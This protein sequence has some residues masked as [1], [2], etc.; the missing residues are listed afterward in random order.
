[1]SHLDKFSELTDKL[2]FRDGVE[3]SWVSIPPS[4]TETT[5]VDAPL[6]RSVQ[7]SPAE[8]IALGLPA[9]GGKLVE[10]DLLLLDFPPEID[11]HS[12]IWF[13]LVTKESSSVPPEDFY[14][15]VRESMIPHLT[16]E[17]IMSGGLRVDGKQQRDP[18]RS[19]HNIFLTK[20]L[21]G[22][23]MGKR[24]LFLLG[25]GG[26]GAGG[27]DKAIGTYSGKIC[28]YAHHI[29]A[30]LPLGE[31]IVLLDTTCA[32]LENPLPPGDLQYGCPII[33]PAGEVI[34]HGGVPN[35]LQSA[36]VIVEDGHVTNISWL[37]ILR[38]RRSSGKLLSINLD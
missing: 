14:R 28:E 16:N 12:Q 18:R 24:P 2:T 11:S 7:L 10:V 37:E 15:T 17:E 35:E 13:G 9:I 33:F 31:Y 20:Y 25:H 1:M 30:S 5:G 32:D 34:L 26:Y 38:N 27:V 4:S 8:S 3:V 6:F 23:S 29:Y 19:P 21:S 22:L 36:C